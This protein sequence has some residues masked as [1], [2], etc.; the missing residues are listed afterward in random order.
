MTTSLLSTLER[1]NV[2][3]KA[4]GI[5]Q[6]TGCQES[7]DLG[8]ITERRT[9]QGILAVD[10]PGKLAG[11]KRNRYFVLRGLKESLGQIKVCATLRIEGAKEPKLVLLDRSADVATDVSF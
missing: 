7:V 6:R 2:G 9:S 10:G 8:E 1:V 4:R 3:A 5:G 11:V